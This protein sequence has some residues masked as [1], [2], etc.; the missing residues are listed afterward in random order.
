MLSQS[1]PI[2]QTRKTE[3]RSPLIAFALSLFCPGLG[4]MYNGDLPRGVSFFILRTIPLLLGPVAVLKWNPAS[5]VRL[6]MGCAFA[7]MIIPLLAA[8]E[9]LVTARRA[10]VLPVR[11]YNAA[12]FYAAFGAVCILLTALC[13]LPP[14]SFFRVARV[15]AAG[16]G[17]LLEKGDWILQRAYGV[18]GYAR[19]DLVVLNNGFTGR[20]M[21]L[22]GDV[23]RHADNIFFVNG[24]ALPLGYLADPVIRSFSPDT[25]DIVSESNEGR[26]Y[27]VRFKAALRLAL[28]G[29]KSPVPQGHVLIASDTRV[30][31]DFAAT[32]PLDSISGR[33]E[34]ILYSPNPRKIGMDSCANL[35]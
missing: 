11:R 31:E 24:R 17:P 30:S 2:M 27:P 14:A 21:A 19:A 1:G 26:K 32:V 25:Y 29:L 13:V 9:S 3:T 23:V 5:C 33:V 20:I 18:P 6:L 34:G 16:R 8:L 10:A 12:G 22:E 7:W 28:P 15:D 4:Q 35:R